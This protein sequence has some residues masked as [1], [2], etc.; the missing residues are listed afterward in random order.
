M[1]SAL[2]RVNI[3]YLKQRPETPKVYDSGVKYQFESDED[4]LSVP[5]ILARRNGDCEDLACWRTAELR[6]RGVPAI[7]F[8]SSKPRVGG[9]TLY[10][11]RVKIGD[12]IEDPS[13]LLGM[14]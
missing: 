2:V 5:E 6:L 4:W 9:G 3:L 13:K 1:L 7:P 10:H 11:I 8:I 14:R 12:K